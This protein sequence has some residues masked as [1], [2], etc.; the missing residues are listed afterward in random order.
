MQRAS[1]GVTVVAIV[2][3]LQCAQ[4]DDGEFLFEER[5]KATEMRQAAMG[6]VWPPSKPGLVL[7]RALSPLWPCR[8]SYRCRSRGHGRFACGVG[9]P[10]R[11]A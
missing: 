2:K 11:L 10:L 6:G 3:A 7:P 8:W 9:S 4:V 5:R 1:S